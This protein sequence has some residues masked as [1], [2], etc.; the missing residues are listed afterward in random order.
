[1]NKL[2]RADLLSLERYAAERPDFRS[3]A[4]AHKK[5]RSVAL[6]AH[7]TALFEDR[8]RQ[9]PDDEASPE[10]LYEQIGR[11]KMEV[12]WLKKKSLP[13]LSAIQ[14]EYS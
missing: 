10:A 11:L 6:G 1:M 2:T 12:D 7:A 13:L 9:K 8:R 4:I 5:Q 14:A 3:R